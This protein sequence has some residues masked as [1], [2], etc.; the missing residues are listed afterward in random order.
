MNAFNEKMKKYI[1]NAFIFHNHLLIHDYNEFMNISY[2]YNSFNLRVTNKNNNI[3][4]I[5]FMNDNC[6]ETCI[7]KD[8]KVIH[9]SMIFHSFDFQKVIEYSKNYT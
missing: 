3:I 2:E 9:D 4:S 5:S 1:Y 6:I 7:V 8:D